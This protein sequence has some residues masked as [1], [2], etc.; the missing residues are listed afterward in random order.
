[1]IGMHSNS[2]CI[3]LQRY[4]MTPLF[5]KKIDKVQPVVGC[6][7]VG[8][9]GEGEYKTYNKNTKKMLS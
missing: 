4:D 2:L 7:G 3:Q 5:W 1:M 8:L 6:G 9:A